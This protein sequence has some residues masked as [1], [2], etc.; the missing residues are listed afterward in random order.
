MSDDNIDNLI[1]DPKVAREF[2]VSLITLWRGRRKSRSVTATSAIAAGSR[3]SSQT[4]CSVRSPS[5][6]RP[7]HDRKWIGPRLGGDRGG[8][9]D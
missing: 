1:P 8:P 4:C 5:V 6:K 9:G 3:P 2:N 7:A